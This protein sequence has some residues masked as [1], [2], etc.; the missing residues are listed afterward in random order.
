MSKTP[1]RISKHRNLD[2]PDLHYDVAQVKPEHIDDI[3]DW[4]GQ[5][6]PQLAG[7]SYSWES[8]SKETPTGRLIIDGINPA[9]EDDYIIWN[10]SYFAHLDSK[11]FGAW[12][13]RNPIVVDFDG[14]KPSDIGPNGLLT[15]IIPLAEDI[16]NGERQS[17][18]GDP[19]ESHEKIAALWSPVLGVELTAHQ[20]ALCMLLLKVVRAAN[21]EELHLDSYVDMVGYATIAGSAKYREKKPKEEHD[22]LFDEPIDIESTRSYSR[23]F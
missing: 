17:V 2:D 1:F 16:L 7:V 19:V 21:S 4:I 18:Y 20:V 13:S 5:N 11:L 6:Y 15:N 23:G 22:P 8:K 10:G 9:H 14:D 12:C 3:C